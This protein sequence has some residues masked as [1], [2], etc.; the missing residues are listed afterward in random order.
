M[1]HDNRVI[2]SGEVNIMPSEPAAARPKRTSIRDR[3]LDMLGK[4][5][6][7]TL[8]GLI[9]VLQAIA[10]YR[11]AANW[12]ATTME[13]K[14][15]Q[16]GSSL[17]SFIFVVMIA[18]M[19]VV[20][21]RPLRK[22]PGIQPRLSALFGAFLSM[23]LVLL[24][25]PG[26]PP[27]WQVLSIVL[28][29]VGS[30][31]SFCVLSRLGRSFSVMAEAR[32]LVTGGPYAIVRHPLYLCEEI[33][34]IGAMLAHLSPSAVAIVAV[35]WLFQLKRMTHEERV[36]RAAFPDY[37]VYAAA[38]PKLFPRLPWGARSVQT[39]ESAAL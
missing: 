9:A 23:S 25:K 33:A 31:L 36:L 27:A 5:P 15:L 11:F 19:T 39:S 18:A 6:I 16:F 28:L 13:Y 12:S 10:V 1:V 24:P 8:F 20:R 17:A 37:A 14:L 29:L 2:D 21:L 35:Q 22:A 3:Y 26:L 34:I 7:A 30:A 32:H 4:L 38:T